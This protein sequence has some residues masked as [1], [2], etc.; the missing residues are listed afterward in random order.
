M[1]SMS[2]KHIARKVRFEDDDN[3]V[4]VNIMRR[5]GDLVLFRDL[6]RNI[7]YL[8]ISE[9][10]CDSINFVT[11]Y[12]NKYIIIPSDVFKLSFHFKRLDMLA[13]MEFYNNIVTAASAEYPY[14]IPFP[15]K[16]FDNSYWDTD[17]ASRHILQGSTNKLNLCSEGFFNLD[18]HIQL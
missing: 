6:E 4:R 11:P 18:I 5:D 1:P 16:L 7:E 8:R 15:A 12:K 14:T 2:S 9:K 3:N 10:C 13:N 17:L